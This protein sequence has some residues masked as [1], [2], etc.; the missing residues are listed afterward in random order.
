MGRKSI[1]DDLRWKIIGAYE[2]TRY[3]KGFSYRK[4][5]KQFEV[6]DKCIRTTIKK[7][8]EFGEVSDSPRSGRPQKLST[9]NVNFLFKL[10]R[11]Q[12]DRSFQSLATEFNKCQRKGSVSWMTVNRALKKRGL[13]AYVAP[14]KPLLTI[15]NRIKRMKWCKERLNWSVERWSRVIFSDES[16][17]EV[18][19]RK[20]R[21]IVKR[22]A[23]E[24][25]HERF[26][27]PRVQGGG[28][29]A[30]IWGNISHKG[31]GCANLYEGRINQH[32]YIE[33]LENHLIPLATLF[34]DQ[35]KDYYFQQDGATAHTAKSVQTWMKENNV[36]VLQNPPKS[37]DLNPIENVWAWMDRQL[38]REQ[39]NNVKELKAL[40]EKIWLQVPTSMCM[41]LIESMPRRV[42]ACYKAKGGHFQA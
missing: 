20:N 17:F 42:Q 12:A 9:R 13:N 16:N 18:I 25:F 24:K 33:T 19:N 36:M 32:R 4:L 21:I 40:L 26:V 39:I 41:K 31:T 8:N 11:A 22:F 34:Y 2:A 7:H 15:K 3:S 1:S 37:P 27:Q 6:S 10:Q 14:R 29:S 5:A 28:G 30:G 23:C 38:I 35:S